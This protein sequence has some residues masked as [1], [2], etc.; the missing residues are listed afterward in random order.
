MN[1]SENQ[2]ISRVKEAFRNPKIWQT[3]VSVIIMALIAIAF[4]HP[5]AAEGNQ[6]RQ[7]DMQQGMAIG[8]ET[9]AY[10]E[11]TGEKSWWTNS[12]FSGMPTFQISPTYQSNHLFEW[13]NSIYGL[14]LPSPSNLLF[15]M[16]IGFF[17]LMLAMNIKWQYGLIGAIAWGFSTYF[18]IIIGAGHIWKFVTLSYIPPTIAGIVLAYRGRWLLGSAL[19]AL[20]AMLQIASNHVQMTY[21]FLFVIV[22]LV[23]AFAVEAYRKQLMRRWA[24][25]TMSLVIA[26]MLAVAANLPSLYNTYTYSKETIRGNHSELTQPVDENNKT[27]GGLDR[28]YITQYSYGRSETFTLLIPNVKGGASARPEHGQ[29][30]AMSLSDLDQAKEMAEKGTIDDLSMQY[31]QYMSQYFGEPEST[32][33]PIYVGV[34]IFALF[35]V[36]CAIVKGPVKWAL[37]VLTILSV[38]LALGRNCMW[39]TDLFIDY[40]PMY[41][42]FRTVES[43]LVIAEFTIPLLAVLALQKLLT[44]HSLENYKKPVIISFGIVAFFCVAGIFMPSVY[45][46]VVTPQDEQISRM[47]TQQLIAQGYPREAVASFSLDNPS[48]YQAVKGLRETMIEKDSLRSLLF[49]AASFLFLAFYAFKRIPQWVAAVAVGLLVLTDLYTVNKRYLNHESF[50]SESLSM[51]DPFP[52]S[53]ADREILKDTTMNYR[54]MDIPRFWQADPSYRHKTIGGYHAAK[55]TRYQDLIDR[56][57]NNILYGSTS[58]ADINVLNMLNAR[59]IIDPSGQIILNDDALGNAWLVDKLTFVDNPDKEMDALSVIDPSNQAVADKKFNGIIS[60]PTPKQPGDTIFETSYAPDRLTYHARSANGSLAVFSE[61]YFPYGWNVTIDGKPANIA[62]VNYVL[63]ALDIP[64]GDHTIVMEFKPASIK[65]TVTVATVAIFLI[66]AMI[67]LA[68]VNALIHYREKPGED[69]TV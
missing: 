57:I 34:I 44:A 36:G 13:L 50:C 52:M 41:S 58:Q 8:E 2:Y 26:A 65:T 10:Q 66:Y 3:V 53:A 7:H 40:I 48:I 35:L 32:N 31:L 27:T 63:R 56:H 62:R 42:K 23:I 37:V 19:A 21:Y 43:I 18:I 30:T 12:L 20:F 69:E 61:I 16:M 47:I 17:I 51:T 1:S 55:L 11:A 29:M 4:F 6:L 24:I 28:D 60:Q 68:I 9:R 67:L 22:G 14:G 5:D 59:Y 39:L 38:L 15:M 33:G 46:K 45:G 25:A 49:L 54:V 64:A